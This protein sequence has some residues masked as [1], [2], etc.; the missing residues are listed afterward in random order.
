MQ[1]Q[2]KDIFFAYITVS[3]ISKRNSYVIN[4][5]CAK[6]R[7]FGLKVEDIY[8]GLQE[9]NQRFKMEPKK[10]KNSTELLLSFDVQL[11][12][13]FPH[14]MEF[15]FDI[16]VV[17]TISNY[18]YEMMDDLWLNDL[19]TAAIKKKLTD[20]EIFVGTDKVIEAHRVILCARSPVL[21]ESLSKIS[22]T[23]DKSIVTFG[24]EFDVEIVKTFLKFLYTG[25]L[26]LST[27]HESSAEVKQL[28]KL[29][30]MYEVE[31]LKNMRQLLNVNPTDVEELTNYLLQL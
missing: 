10:I 31:T 6:H 1:Y 11:Q 16:K 7:S 15:N 4:F 8:C 12:F 13:I 23:A 20:I 29:A 22:N 21:N 25:R 2:N 9:Q 3:T 18:Y 17:S 28:S 19:W 14:Q 30:T 24:E 27:L 26:E 5:T